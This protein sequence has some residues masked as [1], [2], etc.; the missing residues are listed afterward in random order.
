MLSGRAAPCSTQLAQEHAAEKRSCGRPRPGWVGPR[1][2][3]KNDGQPENHNYKRYCALR[4]SRPSKS[5]VIE[6]IQFNR[7]VLSRIVKH[8]VKLS[9]SSGSELFV[10]LWT[11]APTSFVRC[12]SILHVRNITESSDNISVITEK[13][14]TSAQEVQ[15]RRTRS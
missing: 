7:M 11:M 8:L 3:S 15:S 1:W 10:V 2:K 4:V 5:K 6:T 14:S 12:T 13:E 9:K